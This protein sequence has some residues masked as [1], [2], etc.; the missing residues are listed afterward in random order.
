MLD[1]PVSIVMI[2]SPWI[3]GFNDVKAAKW[4]LVVAGAVVL[5]TNAMTNHELGL[6]RVIPMH[7]HLWA[8]AI[9]GIVLALSPW[10][11]GFADNGMAAWLTPLLFGIGELGAAAISDPWPERLD[12]ADRERRLLHRTG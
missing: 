10:I 5:A 7:M 12:V 9:V 8:D 3:F 1:Y 11:F 2:A 6:V 4:T